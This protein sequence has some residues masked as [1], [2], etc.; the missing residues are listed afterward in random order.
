MH[1]VE[2]PFH[3]LG[4][5]PRD[6]R[7]RILELAEERSLS[8]DPAV[9]A[10]AR[11][12]LTNPRN[13]LAAEV[14]WLPGLEP[15][16]ARAAME[17]VQRSASFLPPWEDLHP[18]ARGNLLAAALPALEASQGDSALTKGLLEL[19]S[20]LEDCEPEQ[21]RA[22][23]NEERA[24]AG[25]PEV[26][27]TSAVAEA[28]AERRRHYRA[29]F[30]SALE[31]LPPLELVS[32]VTLV[33]TEATVRGTRL[34]PGLVEDLV[35][36]YEV[37]AQRFLDAEAQSVEAL[38]DAVRQAVAKRLPR[39][40]L[41]RLLSRI[42]DVVTNWDLVAQPIQLSSMSR[43]VDHEQSHRVAAA[44][45]GLSLEL[46]NGHG[47]LE[48]SQ[49]LTTLLQDVFREVP[50]VAEATGNDAQALQ[51][52]AQ[53]RKEWERDITY[54]AVVGT[55]QKSPLKISPVGIDWQGV[56]W[57]LESI[58][59]LRWGGI[60]E[61]EGARPQFLLT[62]GDRDSSATITTYDE[63][64][65]WTL[66]EKF[67]RA[68]GRRLLFEMLNALKQGH[69]LA[70]GDAVVRDGGVI[71]SRKQNSWDLSRNQWGD[72]VYGS[73]NQ[74]QIESSNGTLVIRHAQER[75]AFAELPYL[76][77]DNVQILERALR[78]FAENPSAVRLSD[79]LSE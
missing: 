78:H 4:A 19:A 39:E 37:E 52:I 46:Y 13:R 25:F 20:L 16:R 26:R 59:R 61:H 68:A 53:Q 75:G 30:K 10:Q 6:D 36:T 42:E 74:L 69:Q 40:L 60:V 24:T 55:F 71:L 54:A 50:R 21:L 7:R 34:A 35:A 41:K 51:E 47:M 27:D 8:M 73:W 72:S 29:A 22:L 45:R 58:T 32:L 5:S 15:E 3:I 12:D 79:L 18:L 14:A 67:W 31:V 9:C 43:G 70:F 65:F 48:E 66:A 33:V 28:L 38:V 17:A 11:A 64:T 62:F 1:L 76:S 23:I 77:V 63:S 2:N 57:P 56:R 44:V 49:F